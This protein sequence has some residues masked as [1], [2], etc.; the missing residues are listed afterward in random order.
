MFTT[1]FYQPILNLLV[2]FYNILPGHDIGLAIIVLSVV[3]KL[4][5]YPLS[6]KSIKSQKAL[7]NLQPKIQ[8]LK[9]KYKDDKEA[10]TKGMMEL[11]KQE[12]VNPLSS[13]LPLLI[14]LPFFWAVFRV[15]RNELTNGSLSLIYPFIYNPGSLSPMAFGLINLAEP[16]WVL[17]VLAGLSQFLQVKLMPKPKMPVGGKEETMGAIMNKQMTYVMPALTVFITLSLPSGLA[18]YWFITTV[19]TI[20]QQLIVFKKEKV[21]S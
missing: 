17:A 14:Q 6:N 3:I 5:L 21:S 7:Q 8:E 1:I 13:C 10:M 11:Y 19:L 18:L 2:W 4:V 9:E 20:L 16:N 12:K 15:F